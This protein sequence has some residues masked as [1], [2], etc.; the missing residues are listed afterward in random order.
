[1][2]E[3]TVAII[4]QHP[5]ILLGMK[6]KKFGEGKYNGFGGGLENGETLEE[7]VIREVMEEA[8]IKVMHPEKIGRILFQFDGNEQDH[9]VHFFRIMDFVGNPTETEEMK[10]EWFDIENIPYEK[11]WEDDKY[12]LPLLLKGKKFEGTF[13]FDKNFKLSAYELKGVRK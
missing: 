9:I 1:M 8:G 2:R 12:W 13:Y 11:M 10:P 7:A 3:E 5:R 6:K 4:Y